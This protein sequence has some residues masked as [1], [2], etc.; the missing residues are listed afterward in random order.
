MTPTPEKQARFR[1]TSPATLLGGALLTVTL[2]GVGL[3][4]ASVLAQ[5]G[6]TT[7][8]AHQTA[9]Q[10]TFNSVLNNPTHGDERN[11]VLIRDAG[12]GEFVDTKELQ[13]GNEYEVYNYYHNNAAA[14]M[15]AVDTRLTVSLPQ[16]VTG[17]VPGTISATVSAV[18]ATPVAVEDSVSV[19]AKTPVKV[20]FVP[21]SAVVHS[22]GPVNSN[23]LPDSVVGNGT[24]LGYERLD[25]S[26]PGGVEHG[27]YVMYRIAVTDANCANGE[28]GVAVTELPRTGT[29]QFFAAAIGATLLV[30]CVAYYLASHRELRDALMGHYTDKLAAAARDD[31]S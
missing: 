18:N 31:R 16:V 3:F 13:P 30:I 26:I 24:L 28:C 1:R 29:G 19:T 7:F 15:R 2:M 23:T 6:R 22:N 12:K 20:S 4:G 8:Q 27:G 21:D 25:G 10:V 11:F 14:T 9:P 5:T 17:T